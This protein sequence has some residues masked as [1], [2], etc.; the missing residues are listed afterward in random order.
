MIYFV[1]GAA[2]FIGSNLVDYLL[3]K[4]NSVIGFDN[5]STGKGEFLENLFQTEVVHK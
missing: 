2:G 3:E 4:N 5:L 1:T